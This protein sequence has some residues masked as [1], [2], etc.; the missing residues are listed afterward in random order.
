MENIQL[1]EHL[2]KVT[3][4]PNIVFTKGQGSYLWDRN[5]HKYLDFING[6]AVNCLG[7]SPKEITRVLTRQSKKL[8]NASPSFYN[9]EQLQFA[10]LITKYSKLDKVFFCST[11]AE[12]NEGAIKIARKYGTTRKNGACEIITF[13]NSFHGRTLATMSASGKPFFKDLFEPKVSGFH[14]VAINDIEELQAK[15]NKSTCA[16]MFELLQGEGGVH[17]IDYQY[18]KMVKEICEKEKI[19]LIFDEIQTGYGRTGK[20]FC[21]EH[22]D[23]IPDIMTLGKGIGGGFPLAATLCKK[24]YDIFSPGEQGGTYTAQPLAMAVG[25]AILNHII[26]NKLWENSEAMGNLIRSELFKLSKRFP[27][28]TIRGKGLLIAFDLKKHDANLLKEICFK[29]RLIINSPQ[30]HTIRL[31]PALNIEKKHVNEMIEKLSASMEE[32]NNQTK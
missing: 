31:M 10:E 21:F 5:N 16:I 18:L 4:R 23:I 15:I 3:V 14:H 1:D 19:L 30:P 24:Q 25:K 8:L 2:L 17:Q 28:D 20:L 32:I 29:N 27:I 7:H 12:A 26:N 13:K 6:W 11:G 22:Y 9:E